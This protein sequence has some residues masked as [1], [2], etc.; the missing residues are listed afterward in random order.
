MIN[1]RKTAKRVETILHYSMPKTENCWWWCAVVNVLEHTRD[2][3]IMFM[4]LEKKTFRFSFAS[5]RFGI[6]YIVGFFPFVH[7]FERSRFPSYFIDKV[8]NKSQFK[9]KTR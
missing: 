1:G 4:E 8:S 2:D 7:S 6:H 3:Y 5:V 9:Q